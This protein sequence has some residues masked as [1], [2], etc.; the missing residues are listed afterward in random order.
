MSRVGQT[1]HRF[2]GVTWW[3]KAPVLAL[4]AFIVLGAAG[5]AVGGGGDRDEATPTATAASAATGTAAP[6]R[7]PQ[8]RAT[9]TALATDTPAPTETWAP[10]AT[11]V[12]PATATPVPPAPVV[13]D[14]SLVIATTEF[15]SV[16]SP[17]AH[18]NVATVV[19]RTSPGAYCS[20]AVTYRSG[21]STAQGL[22]PKTAGLDGIIS[23]SWI[24][25]TRTTPGDWPIEVT[26]DG[27]T[28]RRTF[29][30]T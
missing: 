28:I 21:P 29:T 7:T 19:V 13:P 3:I 24:V 22:D 8:A 12:L 15:I 2:W 14:P 25:G 27:Q 16:S 20:I 30:V 23:W 9:A 26:C 10:T 1:W 17:V 6:S 11:A 5:A 4:V 18:G